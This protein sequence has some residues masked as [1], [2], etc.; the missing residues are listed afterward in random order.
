V[1]DAVFV[2][3]AV[4]YMATLDDL[5]AAIETAAVHVRPGG[6]A[7]LVPDTLRETYADEVRHGGHDGE[8]GRSLRYLEWAHDP[9][10]SDTTFDVDFAVLLREP[11]APVRLVHDH[12]VFGLFARDVW[13]RLIT[14]AGL[15]LVTIDVEHPH[16]GEF[17]AFAAVRPA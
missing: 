8:D 13:L 2:H 5:R 15:D 4:M 3:D 9:D 1:F 11:D 7:L 14:G 12:H 16:P 10:P 6:V 17:E